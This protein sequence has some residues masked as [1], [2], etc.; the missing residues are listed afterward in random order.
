MGCYY[1]LS[2]NIAE[3]FVVLIGVLIGYPAPLV[4]TQILWLN[5]TT[6]GFPAIALAVE[7]SEP[8]IMDEGPKPASEPLIEKVM[9]TGI[10]IQTVV[11]TVL[12]LLSY[13]ITWRWDC[14]SFDPMYWENQEK[15]YNG[16][17]TSYFLNKKKTTAHKA[18]T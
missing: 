4:P 16:N 2:T 1:L 14:G 18:T 12:V 7:A 5:L 9:K 15:L 3:V 11:L 10:F 17:N 13:C 8:G 6:D